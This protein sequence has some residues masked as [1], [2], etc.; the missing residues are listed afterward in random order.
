MVTP[1][2]KKQ[3]TSNMKETKEGSNE[4]SRENKGSR[5]QLRNRNDLWLE[6]QKANFEMTYLKPMKLKKTPAEL[7]VAKP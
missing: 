3:L 7:P 6:E 4:R 1:K 5:D 2:I